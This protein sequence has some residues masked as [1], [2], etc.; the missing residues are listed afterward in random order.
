MRPQSRYQSTDGG[1]V[2]WLR[3]LHPHPRGPCQSRVG[4]WCAVAQLC[5]RK[6][7]HAQR[8]T[9]PAIIRLFQTPHPSVHRPDK[10]KPSSANSSLLWRQPGATYTHCQQVP[11]LPALC[12][13][14]QAYDWH[15]ASVASES[16]WSLDATTA[17]LILDLSHFCG[18]QS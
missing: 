14:L 16:G 8:V 5:A 6:L 10:S 13:C 1:T 12:H 17:S 15:S 18:R 3:D 4:P 9:I 2:H 11:S 7:L